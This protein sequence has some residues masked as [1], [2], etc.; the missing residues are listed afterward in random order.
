MKRWSSVEAEAR[1]WL[2]P[3]SAYEGEGWSGAVTSSTAPK[4]W[5][6]GLVRIDQ[7]NGIDAWSGRALGKVRRHS[8][9][10]Q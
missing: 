8:T 7:W 4:R 3:S 9:G 6:M 5:A 10:R 2:V 1:G